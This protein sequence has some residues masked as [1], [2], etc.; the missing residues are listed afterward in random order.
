MLVPIALD[1]NHGSYAMI[2][3]GRLAP[4]SGAIQTESRQAYLA[5]RAHAELQAQGEVFS[6]Q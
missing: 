2:S 1:K 5:P 4:T 6:R 3:T